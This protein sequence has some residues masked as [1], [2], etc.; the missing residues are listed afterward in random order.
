MRLRN[1]TLVM[2]G[3][4]AVL[5]QP[6]TAQMAPAKPNAIR[7][8][9]SQAAPSAA[10]PAA[11]AKPAAAAKPVAP[12]K[13]AVAAAKPEAAAKP[14]APAA[15]ASTTPTPQGAAAPAAG[16]P[17]RDPFNPLLGKT[18]GEG[19]AVPDRLPPG[20][21]GLMIGTLRLDG[22]VRGPNGMLAVVSNPQQRVYFLR[23][24]DHIFDGQVLR[25]TME[26]VSFQQM[27]RDAFGNSLEHEVTRRL[28]PNPG[29]QR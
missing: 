11:P 21:A 13:P 22:L 5:A 3:M 7:T 19:A 4:I 16:G 17:R 15:Q 8:Q 20:K 29:E 26:A 14:A 2:A 1:F 28:Y 25:I 12:A 10:K 9:L 18:T 6:M 24:G 23:E 27:G